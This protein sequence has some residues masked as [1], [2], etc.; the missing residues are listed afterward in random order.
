MAVW[1]PD[2][3]KLQARIRDVSLGG[4]GLVL[5]RRFERGT[6]L[7][8]DVPGPD[9]GHTVFARV[10]R[11]AQTGSDSW[12]IGCAFVGEL[13][14]DEVRALIGAG[15]D[16]QARAENG[17]TTGPAQPDAHPELSA[18]GPMSAPAGGRV[19]EDV[20]FRVVLPG[21]Q[22]LSR[23]LRRLR[24]PGSWP[25]RPGST[26]QAWAGRKTPQRRT[27][28]LRVRACERDA[29]GWVVTCEAPGLSAAAARRWLRVRAN[30]DGD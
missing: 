24:L 12:L 16:P 4:I 6:G 19:V 13:I 7:A 18:L 15:A 8:I 5:P 26:V 29:H 25:L 1:S 17:G 20:R 27:L 11:V 30:G 10:V 23:R 3:T 22:T 9:G 14:D 2:Q 28:A 21:G